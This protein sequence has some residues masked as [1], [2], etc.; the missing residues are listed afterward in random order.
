[1]QSLE[2]FASLWEVLGAMEKFQPLQSQHYFIIAKWKFW[3]AVIYSVLDLFHFQYLKMVF[4]HNSYWNILSHFLSEYQLFG[5]FLCSTSHVLEFLTLSLVT[6]TPSH[7]SH[8]LVFLVYTLGSFIHISFQFTNFHFSCVKYI[9]YASY[10]FNH[11]AHRDFIWFCFLFHCSAF[12][13]S[14][15]LIMLIFSLAISSKN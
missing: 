15:F 7:N 8:F 5:I 12:M 2:G 13:S 4:F 14:C 6:H 11:D 1:V 9:V 3:L 10:A